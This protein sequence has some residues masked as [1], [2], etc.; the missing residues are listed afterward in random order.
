MRK[1]KL[2]KFKEILLQQRKKTLE[3][4]T[5]LWESIQESSSAEDRDFLN[6]IYDSGDGGSDAMDRE[7]SFL[8]LAREDKY[9]QQIDAALEDI[10]NGRYGIC[11]VCNKEI[12]EERL[13][14]VP[15]TSI[16]IKCKTHQ[17]NVPRSREK[18]V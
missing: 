4:R 17:S 3:E 16:C 13:K 11:R 1:E 9:L 2:N 5:K 7:K 6:N 12:S 14:A 10:K 8:L 18:D 15:T